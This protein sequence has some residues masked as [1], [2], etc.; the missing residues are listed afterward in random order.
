ME[1]NKHNGNNL[2]SFGR[3][4]PNA[5]SKLRPLEDWAEADRALERNQRW[6]ITHAVTLLSHHYEERLEAYLPL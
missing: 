6:N 3:V 4:V 2:I 5:F 1:R